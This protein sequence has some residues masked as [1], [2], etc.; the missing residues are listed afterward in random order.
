MKWLITAWKHRVW[1]KEILADRERVERSLDV[2]HKLE[3]RCL[4]LPQYRYEQLKVIAPSYIKIP[5]IEAAE[6]DRLIGNDKKLQFL[7]LTEDVENLKMFCYDVPIF[8]M[9]EGD[10]EKAWN[11]NFSHTMNSKNRT[12]LDFTH[13][14]GSYYGDFKE[15]EQFSPE[16]EFLSCL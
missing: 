15:L 14:T 16:H 4:T 3:S 9:H 1:L 13:A 8:E 12:C 7:V 10:F 6:G 5:F 2:L 11:I